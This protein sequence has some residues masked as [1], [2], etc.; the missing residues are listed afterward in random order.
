M[1]PDWVRTLR[2][3]CEAADVP[4]LFKQWGEYLPITVHGDDND[5]IFYPADGGD[6]GRLEGL[7][8]TSIEVDGQ[9]FARVGK[10]K[11]GR[12]I[13]GHTHDAYPKEPA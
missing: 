3:Q 6:P 5:P 7:E 12:M 11:S 4:F 9:A 8:A 10:K 1:H 13:D 2:D